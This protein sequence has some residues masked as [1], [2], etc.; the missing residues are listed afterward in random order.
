MDLPHTPVKMENHPEMYNDP[1]AM[2]FRDLKYLQQGEI[3]RQGA[4]TPKMG[5]GTK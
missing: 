2:S 4:R 5:I 3:G 1:Q